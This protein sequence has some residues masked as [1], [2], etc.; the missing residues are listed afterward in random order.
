MRG[1]MDMTKTGIVFDLDGTLWDATAMAARIWNGVFEDEGLALRL[2]AADVRAQMGRTMAEI[3][4]AF[5][6]DLSPARQAEIMALLGEQEVLRMGEG[7]GKLYDGV[8]EVLEALST[9]HPLF[10]VSNCQRDYARGF[11]RAFGFEKYFTDYEESGRSGLGK[12]ENIRLVLERNGV[13]R[14]VYVGDTAGD[15]RSAHEAGVPFV[16][17]RYGF[18]HVDGAEYMIDD[19]RQLP[20]IIKRI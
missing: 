20:G 17:A 4:A 6:P 5:F 16:F 12:A 11:I 14:G 7:G 1:T 3:G 18:G 15:A 2:T 10:I 13:Q 9:K 19:I 8:P